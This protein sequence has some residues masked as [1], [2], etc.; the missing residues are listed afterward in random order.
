[1]RLTQEWRNRLTDVDLRSYASLR[2]QL[3]FWLVGWLVGWLDYPSLIEKSF[4]PTRIPI[5]GRPYHNLGNKPTKKISYR[6]MIYFFFF[7]YSFSVKNFW[8]TATLFIEFELQ[9]MLN[10]CRVCKRVIKFLMPVGRNS[11]V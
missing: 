3:A 11:P 4:T 6:S 5:S 10:A 8:L 2:P 7:I 9:N 1:M